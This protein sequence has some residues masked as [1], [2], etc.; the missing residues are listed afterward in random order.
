[1]ADHDLT[2]WDGVAAHV[3]SRVVEFFEE[4]SGSPSPESIQAARETIYAQLFADLFA[5][6]KALEPKDSTWRCMV[7]GKPAIYPRPSCSGPCYEQGLKN[8]RAGRPMRDER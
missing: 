6:V 7:C 3:G 1:M 2:T 5:R 4:S 8:L